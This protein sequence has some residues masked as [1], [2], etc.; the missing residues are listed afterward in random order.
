LFLVISSF[1]PG[2]EMDF[3]ISKPQERQDLIAFLK[4]KNGN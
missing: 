4:Q 2:N 3:L 1:I